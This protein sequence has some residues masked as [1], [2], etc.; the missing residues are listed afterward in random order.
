[1]GDDHRWMYDCWKKNGAHIDE[2]WEKTDNFIKR[3]FSLVTTVKIRCP[4]SYGY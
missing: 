4:F 2:W 1:M 3:A